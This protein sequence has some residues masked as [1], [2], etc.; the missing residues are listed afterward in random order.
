MLLSGQKPSLVT[1]VSLIGTLCLFNRK[2]KIRLSLVFFIQRGFELEV[3][4]MT[5]LLGFYLVSDGVAL[6]LFDQV[7]HKDAVLWSAMASFLS[8]MGSK[9][10]V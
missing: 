6:T 4:V 10:K 5:V 7:E 9:G 1:L 8:R 2:N 3:Q